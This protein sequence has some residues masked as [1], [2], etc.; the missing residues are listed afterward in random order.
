MGL[1]QTIFSRLFVNKELEQKLQRVTAEINKLKAKLGTTDHPRKKYW[2]NRKPKANITYAGRVVP[3]MDI[4]VELDVTLLITPTD[5][6][7]HDDIKKNKLYV[8]DPLKCNANILKI[9]KHIQKS[10]YEYAFDDK[11][12][13]LPELWLYPYETRETQ[14]GDCDDWGITIA[15]YLIA[16]GV[17]NWRVRIVCGTTWT[18]DGHLTVYTLA[19]DLKSWHHINS[20]TPIE[21][22]KQ[23][24]L[25]D[26][27]KSNDSNDEIGI[28]DVWFSFNN[29]GAW[30]VFE[31]SSAKKTYNKKVKKLF[32]ILKKKNS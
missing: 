1:I 32:R 4:P 2:D 9:Y 17:P 26:M 18:G 3:T 24:K 19:D 30:H 10:Y 23:K 27:P 11:Q 21:W 31:T 16:A 20:T 15:S 25:T 28:K 6:E 29:Y 14:R 8:K 22:I 7:I 13:G 5:F 12:F